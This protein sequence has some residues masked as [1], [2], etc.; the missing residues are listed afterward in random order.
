MRRAA[1]QLLLKMATDG[2]RYWLNFARCQSLILG[3]LG[4]RTIPVGKEVKESVNQQDGRSHKEDGH[5][6]LFL[7]PGWEIPGNHELRVAGLDSLHSI[8]PHDPDCREKGASQ[9]A[10]E[11]DGREEG[12]LADGLTT[13]EATSQASNDQNDEAENSPQGRQDRKGHAMTVLRV[14]LA[15]RLLEPSL[16][17]IAGRTTED[18]PACCAKGPESR[19]DQATTKRTAQCVSSQKQTPPSATLRDFD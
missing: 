1:Y 3:T 16:H 5:E 6:I 7:E 9:R 10:A 11:L 18:H 8:S 15:V 13:W 12:A 14:A 2:S 17:E 19:T 4:V